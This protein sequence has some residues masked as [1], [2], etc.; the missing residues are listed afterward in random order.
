MLDDLARDQRGQLLERRRQRDLHRQAEIREA[1]SHAL[2]P[3][4]D[5][6]RAGQAGDQRGVVAGMRALVRAF[7][8]DEAVDLVVQRIVVRG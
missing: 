1:G 3:P 8:A 2:R 5:R 7:L 4:G 6:L